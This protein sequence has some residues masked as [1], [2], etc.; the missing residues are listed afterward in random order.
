VKKDVVL[1]KPR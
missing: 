1:A